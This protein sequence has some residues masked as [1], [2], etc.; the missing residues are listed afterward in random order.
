MRQ[1]AKEHEEF[2]T[3]FVSVLTRINDSFLDRL[4]EVDAQN[5]LRWDGQQPANISYV[6]SMVDALMLASEPPQN[7]S[8]STILKKRRVLD[9]FRQIDAG[10][11][12]SCDYFGPFPGACYSPTLLQETLRDTAEFLLDQKIIANLGRMQNMG[13]ANS[14]QSPYS[15]C[16]GDIIDGNFLTLAQR[17]C[18][19]SYLNK[20][21]P[22]GLYAANGV[23]AGTDTLL[24][25]FERLDQE[26]SKSP[27]AL[28]EV[29]R[30]VD[31]DSTC[32]G[33][34]KIAGSETEL[35]GTFG[36]G[37]NGK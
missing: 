12:S 17:D 6:P 19:K 2:V 21:Y 10:Q 20:C 25:E 11:Q 32:Q 5:R 1:F 28:N 34:V 24:A 23:V 18:N 22:V 16:G 9:L 14:C 4:G 15:F 35:Q 36:D 31:G 33:L 26:S 3:H 8:K 30:S 37:A 7:P 13:D 29:G 27:F